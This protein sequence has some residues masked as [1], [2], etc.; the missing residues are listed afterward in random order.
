MVLFR[1]IKKDWISLSACKFELYILLELN[2]PGT[3][4][5][6][7]V[8]ALVIIRFFLITESSLFEFEGVVLSKLEEQILSIVLQKTGVGGQD[9]E[10][11]RPHLP[12]V[13]TP[14]A[15]LLKVVDQSRLALDSP[16]GQLADFLGIETFPTLPVELL[17]KLEDKNWVN[18]I[19]KRIADIAFVLTD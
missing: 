2:Y 17:K 4:T 3:F 12:V 7:G 10:D 19:Y 8:F 11:E 1:L 9:T 14:T 18:K 13:L 6:W 5:L 15:G 16:I